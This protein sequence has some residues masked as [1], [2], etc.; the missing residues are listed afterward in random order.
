MAA[1]QGVNVLTIIQVGPNTSTQ[2][3]W[4]FKLFCGAV[5]TKNRGFWLVSRSLSDPYNLQLM[6][7]IMILQQLG[8]DT[9]VLQLVQQAGC[10]YA[11]APQ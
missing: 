5:E 4:S 9:S 10:I 7:E 2:Q 8:Y 11:G 1:L 6:G 3:C